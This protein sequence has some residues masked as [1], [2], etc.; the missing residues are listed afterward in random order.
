MANAADALREALSSLFDTSLALADVR[1]NQIMK[2]LSGWAAV[3]AVPTLVTSFVGMNVGFPLQGSGS[4]FWVYF[5]LMITAS[6]V[7]YLVFP[8]QGLALIGLAQR[9]EEGRV[10]LRRKSPCGKCAR[11]L[12]FFYVVGC[13][14]DGGHMPGIV[15]VGAQ[16][17]DEGRVRRPTS[18]VTGSTTASATPAATTPATRWLSAASATPCT[19]CPRAC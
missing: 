2:K 17:G 11:G 8:G 5:L 9:L 4:G 7:L 1:L 15:V 18:W 10:G 3:L 19:C 14:K 6:V 12:R 16:W 13:E